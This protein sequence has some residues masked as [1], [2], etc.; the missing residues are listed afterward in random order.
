MQNVQIK[1]IFR[2]FYPEKRIKLD[3]SE[4]KS[5][6]LEES[7]EQRFGVGAVFEF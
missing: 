5:S 7:F 2:D 1:R 3:K 6:R 4:Q